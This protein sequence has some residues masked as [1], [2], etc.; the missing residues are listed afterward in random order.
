MTTVDPE[1]ATMVTPVVPS[2]QPTAFHPMIVIGVTTMRLGIFI[3]RITPTSILAWKSTR[4]TMST[5]MPTVIATK[6]YS[7]MPILLLIML[8]AFST[9]GGASPPLATRIGLLL[10]TRTGVSQHGDTLAIIRT[11]AAGAPR[12]RIRAFTPVSTGVAFVTVPTPLGLLT[13]HARTGCNV[14]ATRYQ[15]TRGSTDA[16]VP[17]P[18]F[19]LVGGLTFLVE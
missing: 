13:L 1:V 9:I 6:M 16:A 4:P 15:T 18:H 10:L 14:V 19:H 5:H 12:L 7:M 11:R 2:C 8:Y 3:T 17:P